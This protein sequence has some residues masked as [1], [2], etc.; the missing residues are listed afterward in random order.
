MLKEKIM[1]Y[2]ELF[3]V[4]FKIG[5]VT[6]GGGMSMLPM[7]QR[8]LVNK[9]G[10]I[11][12]EEM[13][14]YFAVGQCTP[15]IIAVNVATFCGYKRHGAAG[16]VIATAGMVFPSWI[17]ITL[18]AGSIAQTTAIP[19]VQKAMQGVYVAVASLLV[20]AVFSVGKKIAADAAALATAVIA[21]LCMTVYT[22]S[23]IYIVI[24]AGIAGYAVQTI[25][26]L[27]KGKKP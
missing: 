21:C 6:F 7:L 27:C 2:I 9:K 5:M 15:G 12:D 10:W 20:H 3:F 22:V 17:I 8:E 4:F 23:G 14:N 18:I 24:A 1:Q 13:L 11:S 25:R 19:W 16:A 26:L